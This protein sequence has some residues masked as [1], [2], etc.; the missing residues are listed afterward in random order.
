MFEREWGGDRLSFF[1]LES[2]VS[3]FWRSANREER[4]QASLA[5]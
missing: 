4:L 1:H 2:R 5:D 3:Q